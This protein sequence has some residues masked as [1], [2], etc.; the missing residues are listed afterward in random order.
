MQALN[1]AAPFG[2]R[3]VLLVQSLPRYSLLI[4][5]TADYHSQLAQL[6]FQVELTNYEDLLKNG[7]TTGNDHAV[8]LVVSDAANRVLFKVLIRQ[9]PKESSEDMLII[10]CFF[11]FVSSM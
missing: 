3:L 9:D 8:A 1:R 11:L 7:L 4:Q 5:Q 2:N 6:S 10:L